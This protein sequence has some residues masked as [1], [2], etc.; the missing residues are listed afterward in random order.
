[1]EIHSMTTGNISTK[2]DLTRKG[3]IAFF[4]GFIIGLIVRLVLVTLAIALI[5]TLVV[6]TPIA[7]REYATIISYPALVVVSLIGAWL[8][9]KAREQKP[10]PFF[11]WLVIGGYLFFYGIAAFAVVVM[12]SSVF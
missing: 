2:S 8:M 9:V 5:V 3:K 11:N 7:I 4:I 10:R 12:L 1:M 6:L